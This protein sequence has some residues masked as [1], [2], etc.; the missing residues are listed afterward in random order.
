MTEK[1]VIIR[2]AEIHLKG[3]NRGFFERV[4]TVNLERSLKG[5]RH[6]LRRTSGRYLVENFDEA[7]VDEICERIHNVFGVH[8]YS[9]GIKT[10]DTIDAIYAAAESVAPT[11]GTFKVESHRADKRYP[12][13]SMQIN[14]E[15]GGRLLSKFQELKVDVHHPDAFVYIDVREN[16]STLVFGEFCK[17]RGGMPVGT[18]GKGLLLISGGIDSRVAGYMMAKRGMTVEDLHF[19]SYP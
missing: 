15:I 3:K 11:I 16:G 2:Y 12:M 8:S 6:E 4:F 14:A 10:E 17:G 13:T 5:L 19:H 7:R 9:V 18:A 1:V